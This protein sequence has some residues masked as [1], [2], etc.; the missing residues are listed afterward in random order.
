A[1]WGTHPSQVAMPNHPGRVAA[2]TAGNYH[3][4]PHIHSPENDKL[5]Y[6]TLRAAEKKGLDI[7]KTLRGITE[8]METGQWKKSFAA[9]G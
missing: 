6:R 3:A 8:R 1:L 9:C 5:I 2:R 4:G 7:G